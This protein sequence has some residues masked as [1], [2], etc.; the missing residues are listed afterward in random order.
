ML[1]TEIMQDYN[2][3]IAQIFHNKRVNTNQ[4]SKRQRE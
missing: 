2:R 4:Y 1:Q 3:F